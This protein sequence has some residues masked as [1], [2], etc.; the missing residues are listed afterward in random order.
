MIDNAKAMV[1]ASFLADSLALGAHWIYDTAQIEKSFGRVDQLLQPGPNS[2]HGTKRRGDFTHYG[3]QAMVL[4]QSVFE[5]EGFS[6]KSFS[7]RWRLLFENYNGYIDQATRMTLSNFGEGRPPDESGSNSHDFSAAARIAPLVYFYRHDVE[8]LAQYSRLQTA[9]TH[10]TPHVLDSA[11][12]FAR[13]AWQVLQGSE[14]VRA[15]TE[16]TEKH[17]KDS[18]VSGW[19]ADGLNSQTK[20]S[21]TAIADFGQSCSVGDAFPG[22]V[23]LISK[24]QDDLV[25]ALVQAVMAGGDSAARGMAVGM[26]LGA[27]LGM[28]AIPESWLSSLNAREKIEACLKPMR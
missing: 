25:E 2:Y 28:P 19:V 23:H 8:L 17:F 3:D 14:P 20:D 6:L 7:K 24:Y 5:N 18:P 11:V 27:H 21:V 16:V 10:R 15:L 13:V 4:L 22:V 26:V 12:F 9:M 1:L